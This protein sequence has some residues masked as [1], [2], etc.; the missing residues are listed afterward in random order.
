MSNKIQETKFGEESNSSTGPVN[1]RC[2]GSDPITIGDA[3][4]ISALTAGNKPIEQSDAAAIRAAEIRASGYTQIA[5]VAAAAELAAEENG[6]TEHVEDKIKLGDLLKDA[7]SMLEEDK[8]VTME[9][10]EGVSGAEVENNP[11]RI[12]YPGGVSASMH[13]AAKINQD[14]Q[15]NPIVNE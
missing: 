13:S 8:A 9:D 7:S 3:L 12:T 6:Q 5:G 15:S 10:A 11:D 2:R 14:P 1:M 4:E